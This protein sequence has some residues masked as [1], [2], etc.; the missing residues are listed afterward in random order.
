MLVSGSVIGP[1]QALINVARFR[2]HANT[3]LGTNMETPK[4][5]YKDYSPSN[6]GLYGFPC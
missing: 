2:K 4:G 5:P 3:L 6:M 1:S